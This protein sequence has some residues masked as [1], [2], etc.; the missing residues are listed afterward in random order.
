MATS[1]LE[2]SDQLRPGEHPGQALQRGL[3]QDRALPPDRRRVGPAHPAEAREPGLGRGGPL[4]EPRQGLRDRPRPLRDRSRP[5]SSTR[6]R[7]RRR[8]RSTSRTSWTSTRSTRSSTTTPTTWCPTRA[9]RR[10]T[11]CWW[12]RWTR[13]GKVA[14]ARVVIR[15][16]ENL[17]AIRPRDGVLT[18]ET[19]LFADEVIPPDSLDEL[20]PASRRRRRRK[21]ELDMATAADRVAL[22]RTSTRTS[23]ATS[24][25][26]ACS[27]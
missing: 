14:I 3:A 8:A 15:S 18:M 17:V 10:P 6:S 7:P 11:S 1:D 2:R 20:A 27:R 23:T 26:S 22:R 5:R 4:R 12:T 25:A 21:R 16:K 9:P 24:T 13:S 19:M